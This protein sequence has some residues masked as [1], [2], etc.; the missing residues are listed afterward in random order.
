MTDEKNP[1]PLP[2]LKKANVGEVPLTSKPN[3]GPILGDMGES[4]ADSVEGRRPTSQ[5]PTPLA[6]KPIP[7]KKT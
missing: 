6:A 4:R 3:L 5:K 1:P 2:E 7:T